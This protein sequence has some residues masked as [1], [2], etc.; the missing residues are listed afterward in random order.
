M[1]EPEIP[2][3]IENI[4]FDLGGV[5]LNIDYQKTIEAFKKLGIE[6]FDEIYSQARQTRLFDEIE[7]GK[8][9]PETFL[10]ELQQYIPHVDT[11]DIRRAWNAMLLD[12]P[13]QRWNLLEKLGKQYRIFL[14]SNTNEIHY[15]EYQNYIARTYHKNFNNLFEKAYYSHLIGFRKPDEECFRF[16]IND[17]GLIPEKTLFL[18]DSIQH[19]EGARK[20]GLNSIHVNNFSINQLFL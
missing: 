3:K 9:S 4:I 7:T 8:I 1:K 16:V 17:A 2:D 6:N 13:P 19:I 20:T 15:T 12:L 11:E 18:D 14:L 10:K 5:I